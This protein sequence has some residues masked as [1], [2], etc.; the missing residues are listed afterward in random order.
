MNKLKIAAAVGALFASAVY[1]SAASAGTTPI[2]FDTNGAAAGGQI[3]VSTFDW[4]PDN[5]LAVGAT[6]L[7]NY[8]STTNFTLYAQGK[9]GNFIDASSQVITGT[10]LNTNYEITFEAGFSEVGYNELLATKASATFELAANPTVNYFKIYYDTAKNANQLAGTGYGDGTLIMTAFGISNTTGFDV[11]WIKDANG[12]PVFGTPNIVNLD[13][14]GTNNYT[15][16]GTVVGQGGGQLEAG[17]S[18]VDTDY[19]K[20]D[21]S[22]FFIDLFFNTSNVTPFNEADP[23]ALVVGHTPVFGQATPGFANGTN[24]L[25]NGNQC[26]A[27]VANC[28]FLFQADANQSF[29]VPEPA[30]LALAGL[31]LTGLG[32]SRRRRQQ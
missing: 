9:L 31:A 6:P 12:R 3:T 16:V 25:G 17:V 7:A 15:G 13:N 10:G 14:F 19:F 26:P 24:G 30:T 27:T 5:A 32:F 28:D 11:L 8:P 1:V 4:S 18:S 23:A 22:K 21:F 29:Q 20:S 2:V